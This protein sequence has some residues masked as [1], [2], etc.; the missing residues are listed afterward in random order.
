[1]KTRSKLLIRADDLGSF[2]GANRAIRQLLQGGLCRN[3]GLMAPATYFAEAAALVRGIPGVCLGLHATLNSEW[4]TSRWRPVL[5]AARV[6][7]LVEPD[8]T[9][10]R[11]PNA[12]HDG[13]AVFDQ[14]LAEI[15]AQLALC[16]D[17]GLPID[18]LDQHMCFGW[19]HEPNRPDHRFEQVLQEFARQEGLCYFATEVVDRKPFPSV[20]G[21]RLH[22]LR[23]GPTDQLTPSLA[24]EALAGV[25]D[26]GLSRIWVAH[27][28]ESDSELTSAHLAGGM[29]G[30]VASE[31]I[32][33][34]QAL[35][36]PEVASAVE[37][38]DIRCVR[39]T[40]L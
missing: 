8:G 9:L 11:T 32:R 22:P 16:R 12:L 23:L 17:A 20:N 36:S 28:S 4:E 3:A 40:D 5:P 19:L 1:M 10:K 6:P 24:A 30:V 15:K 25:A 33:E 38:L 39:A 31:R 14:M 18:Y 27:P 26:S 34:W 21:H 13:G 37:R 35:A 29:P 7:C 2:R